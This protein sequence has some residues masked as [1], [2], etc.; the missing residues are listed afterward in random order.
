MFARRRTGVVPRGSNARLKLK[1]KPKGN[2]HYACEPAGSN[3]NQP[4]CD[5]FQN[6]LRTLGQKAEFTTENRRL[7][8]TT[9]GCIYRCC[10]SVFVYLLYYT[11]T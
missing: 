9:L 10:Q 3:E 11:K 6:V 8:K 4:L 7:I 1:T 2:K 5:I